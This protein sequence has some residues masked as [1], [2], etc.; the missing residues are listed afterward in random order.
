M[1]CEG[2]SACQPPH[3][4]GLGQTYY[5]GCNAPYAAGQT[6]LTAAQ[7]AADAWGAGSTTFGTSC[8]TSCVERQRSSDGKCAVWCYGQAPFAGRVGEPSSGC[9]LACPGAFSP[10]WD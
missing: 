8:G 9:A 2:G 3:A 10:T 1:C 5:D 7:A 6:T 4:N